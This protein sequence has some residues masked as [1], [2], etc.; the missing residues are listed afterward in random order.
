MESKET[1]RIIPIGKGCDLC[2]ACTCSKISAFCYFWR[3]VRVRRCRHLCVGTFAHR[4]ERLHNCRLFSI[5]ACFEVRISPILPDKSKAKCLS[6]F[7]PSTGHLCTFA[8]RNQGDVFH[9]WGS[10]TPR[11]ISF[12]G[13]RS[14]ACRFNHRLSAP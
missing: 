5:F 9:V 8:S 10:D 11:C 2:S 3:G 6:L 12:D 14:H 4:T 1:D 7:N 13:C